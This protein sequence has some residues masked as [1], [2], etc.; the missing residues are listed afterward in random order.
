MLNR[1][2]RRLVYE[3]AYVPEHL[4]DYVEPITRAEA[5]LQDHCLCFLRKKHLLFVGYPLKESQD[6]IEMAYEAACKRFHP[7]T[8]AIIAPRIWLPPQAYEAQPEDRYYRLPLPAPHPRPEVAYMVRRAAQEL[9]VRRGTFGREHGRLVKAFLS[10]HPL[11]REQKEIYRSI[12]RYLEHSPSAW[13]L[14]ARKG[15][16]LTAF[17]IL[18]TGSARYAYYLFNI[19]S[20][21]RPVP[22]AS[23]LLFHEMLRLA[24][25]EGKEALNLGLGIHPG[26]R[27]FKEKWGGTP[28]L[29]H[30]SALVTRRAFEMGRLAD[31][32]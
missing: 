24:E 23:D 17:T 7:T 21:K 25:K 16:Q 6:G 14:E 5:F 27:R 2:E 1:E 30:A 19:R 20:V 3:Y 28:F 26:V 15:D 22:G 8:V 18:D 9:R 10:S 11:G 13:L 4:P 32:L 29:T 12:P 31:K